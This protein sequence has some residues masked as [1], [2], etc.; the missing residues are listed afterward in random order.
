M[1]ISRIRIENFR[2][3]STCDFKPGSLCTLV[4][5]NNAGKSNI[6]DALGR[7]LARDWVSVGLFDDTDF[8]RRNTESPIVIEIQFDPPLT[9]KRFKYSDSVD[10]PIL[11]FTVSTYK[12]ATGGAKPGDLRLEQAC[13][14]ADE[15]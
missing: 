6:L 11:R 8:H 1:A 2:S 3:I 7:V 13:R 10:I 15:T 5:E 9:Y 4:G 12:K 14:R